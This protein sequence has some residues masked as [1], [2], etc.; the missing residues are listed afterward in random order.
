MAFKYP[1]AVQETTTTV[2][3]GILT[4]LGAVSGRLAF[5]SQLSNNDT[6]VI[7]T[8]DGTDWEVSEATYTNTTGEKLTRGAVL[9]STNGGALVNWGIGTRNVYIGLSGTVVESLLDSAAV[10]GLL[11]QTA[12]NIY[13]RR[14]VVNGG[15][16]NVVNSDAVAG[17]ISLNID[18][19][20]ANIFTALQSFDGGLDA[21]DIVLSGASNTALW[22]ESTGAPAGKRRS[23]F[24]V[25]V[26][27]GRVIIQA[28]DDAGVA[29]ENLFI[30]THDAKALATTATDITYDGISIKNPIFRGALVSRGTAFSLPNAASTLI[31]FDSE[32]YDTSGIH[33]LITN[34]TR[35]TVPAGVTKIKLAGAISFPSSTVGYRSLEIVKLIGSSETFNVVK[36]LPIL[37]PMSI[38][39]VSPVLSVTGGDYYELRAY[40]NSG[41]TMSLTGGNP[42]LQ[43]FSMEVIE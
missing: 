14:K 37:G 9:F 35:L 24:V 19:A 42:A 28:L 32:Q 12:K 2:G 33:S 8:E 13:A 4:L 3:V 15:G 7:V 38:Q 11:V 26:V 36:A 20:F 40:Q 10:N 23:R 27:T 39:T 43:W 25:D 22:L 30:A 6:T 17:N 21:T 34:P 41:S 31:P 1:E 16:V 5:S 29:V 18:P